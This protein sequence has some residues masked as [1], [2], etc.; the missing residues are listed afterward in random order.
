MGHGD[1]R[2]SLLHRGCH[3]AY[4]VR[5]EGPPVLFIQG[6]GVHGDGWAPQVDALADRYQCLT[7]DNRGMGQSR[8]AAVP[9][10]VEQMADDARALMDARG[11]GSAHVVGHSLGG[12]V[13]LQLALTHRDR[14]RGLCL[15]CTF[16]RGRDAAPLS[17]RMLW[18]GLRVQF[19]TRAV[20]RRAFLELVMPP[21]AL[22]GIDRDVLAA[23]LAPTFGHDLG[24]QPAVVPA[25]LRAM[26]AYDAIPRLAELAGL[27]T[28]VV[29]AEHDPIAPPSLGRALAA[30]I[31][32]A[33]FVELPDASHGV[34]IS[35]PGRVNALLVEH[36]SAA[37]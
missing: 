21:A 31:P 17:R 23:S 22:R 18:A 36:L 37:D 20:R 34:T 4:A 11:W 27:P 29:G 33:R 6:V 12:P 19:G 25:Q 9:V 5:G 35:D 24:E 32:G 14:V 30:G 8:P 3:L 16:A 2:H 1:G 15:L 13:A 26:R 7:F 10:T 28:L